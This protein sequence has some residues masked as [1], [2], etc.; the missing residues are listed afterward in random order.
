MITFFNEDVDFTLQQKLKT[1]SWLKKVAESEGFKMGN[2]NY[3]FCSDNYLHQ[4]N[5]EYLDHDTLTDIITFDNSEDE[6]VIEGDIFISVERVEDNAKE[7]GT[8]FANEILRVLVHGVLHLCGYDDHSDEDELGMRE[9]E[10]F[11]LQQFS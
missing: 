1:K 4:I 8:G 3:I 6:T 2:L 5:V 7:L 11:Y 9:K 10:N